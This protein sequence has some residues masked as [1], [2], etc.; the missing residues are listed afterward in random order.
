MKTDGSAEMVV[1]FTTI[2][3][4]YLVVSLFCD[5]MLLLS[6]LYWPAI[7][8]YIHGIK[9][10]W[11]RVS[12]I[13]GK[14]GMAF[15]KSFTIFQKAHIWSSYFQTNALCKFSLT[16]CYGNGFMSICS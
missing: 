16:N 10:F 14:A 1:A 13:A 11:L 15:P 5:V 12:G 8:I 3:I 4:N 6:Y 9:L 2:E 7:H